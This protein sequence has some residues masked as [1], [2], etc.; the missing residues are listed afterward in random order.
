MSGSVEFKSFPK[1]HRLSREII[2][3]EKLDGTNAGILIQQLP[4]RSEGEE[5]SYPQPIDYWYGPD[6]SAWGM[7]A[8]SRSRFIYPAEDNYGFAAWARAN[9]EQLKLLGPGHHFGE[10]WGNG[11]QR[12]YGLTEKRFSLFNV[13]RWF[14][15]ETHKNTCPDCCSIVPLLYRGIFDEQ[16]INRLLE[17][18]KNMGSSA[19]PGFMNPEGIVVYHTAANVLFKKTLEH[20]KRGKPV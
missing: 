10:W 3:T 6:A 8:Q 5:S 1:I 2:I 17:S 16:E 13:N 19:V 9:A 14:D 20:D 7:W 12:G 15:F 11:I 4:H 18:L